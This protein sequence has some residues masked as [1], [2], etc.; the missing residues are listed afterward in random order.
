MSSSPKE[1][2]PQKDLA[3]ALFLSLIAT[4]IMFGCSAWA[5]VHREDLVIKRDSVP[6]AT[7]N[8][9]LDLALFMATNM[10]LW[11]GV[12]FFVISYIVFKAYRKCKR[13]RN[14]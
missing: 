4:V 8:S 11:L 7:Y 3:A 5:Y 10:T 2:P 12:T 13:Q 14:D 1:R 6:I 9:V